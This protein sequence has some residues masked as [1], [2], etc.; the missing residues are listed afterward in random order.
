VTTTRRL[1]RLAAQ[2]E[3]RSDA[4]SYK[5]CPAPKEAARVAVINPHLCKIERKMW[6]VED[7]EFFRCWWEIVRVKFSRVLIKVLILI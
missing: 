1:E 7:N 5:F 3:V 2:V 4:I 6:V